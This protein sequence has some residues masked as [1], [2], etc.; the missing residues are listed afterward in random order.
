M[1]L[2]THK[3]TAA[4]DPF[5]GEQEFG[6]LLDPLNLL[7]KILIVTLMRI[8]DNIGFNRHFATDNSQLSLFINHFY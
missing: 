3:A 6:D 8:I 1:R 5:L 7:W 2:E 4:H